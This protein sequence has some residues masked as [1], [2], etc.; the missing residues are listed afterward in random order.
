MT[1][2]FSQTKEIGL[3]KKIVLTLFLS[4]V[5]ISAFADTFVLDWTLDPG[6]LQSILYETLFQYAQDH[7]ESESILIEK[8]V[9]GFSMTLVDIDNSNSIICEFHEEKGYQVTF[10]LETSVLESTDPKS[11][12]GVL[13]SVFRNK[14]LAYS[15][16]GQVHILIKEKSGSNAIVLGMRDIYREDVSVQNLYGMRIFARRSLLQVVNILNERAQNLGIPFDRG[17]CPTQ[18]EVFQVSREIANSTMAQIRGR[19]DMSIASGEIRSIFERI[20]KGQ[21]W[22]DDLVKEVMTENFLKELKRLLSENRFLASNLTNVIA[23]HIRQNLFL[24]RR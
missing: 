16:A 19:G 18:G 24:K 4:F 7:E 21:N 11:L 23:R 1:L 17:R 5:G 8:I 3:M 10:D 12:P 20:A 6:S 13:F 15:T 9:K 2:C 22:S 14:G